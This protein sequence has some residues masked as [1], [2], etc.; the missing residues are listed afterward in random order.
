MN[1]YDLLVLENE[2]IFMGIDTIEVK[3]NTP[4]PYNNID[5]QYMRKIEKRD[6]NAKTYTY[7]LNPDTANSNIPIYDSNTYYNIADYMISS[8][9]L[10]EPTKTRIDFRF[11]CFNNNYEKYAKLNK[12][13]ILLIAYKYNLLNV[14]ESTNPLILKPLTVRAQNTRIEIENYNKALANPNDVVKNRLEFR[15]KQLYDN[16]SEITKEHRE[17]K[18]W[19]ERIQ[20]S[21]T[22]ENYKA[23]QDS[24]NTSLYENYLT[25]QQEVKNFS[26]NEF[27]HEYR[28]S[29]FTSR[30]LADL[31]SRIGYADPKQ[32][33]KKYVKRKGT[34][35]FSLKDLTIYTDMLISSGSRFFG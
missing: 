30:Q 29:I 5:K 34:V 35:L 17:F 7:I 28:N 33:A 14:Y 26:T 13:L 3:S 20:E 8:L 19:C 18:K 24:L 6:T 10:T 22:P 15:S 31:Y 2:G 23:L 1:K 12:L 4:T 11:D 21:I 25:E 16:D 27:L 32:S 9:E